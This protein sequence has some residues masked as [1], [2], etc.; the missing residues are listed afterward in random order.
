MYFDSDYLNPG[1]ILAYFRDGGLNL[2]MAILFDYT[3]F[4]KDVLVDGNQTNLGSINATAFI[5]DGSQ[6]TGLPSQYNNPFNQNLNTTD[7]V[8]FGNI[9]V[10][11][12]LVIGNSTNNIRQIKTNTN[13]IQIIANSTNSMN[14]TRVGIQVLG[15][16]AF[17]G[18]VTGASYTGGAISG[19]TGTHTGAVA[20]NIANMMNTSTNGV[21]ITDST[22]ASAAGPTR[23]SPRLLFTGRAWNG[24]ASNTVNFKQEVATMNTTPTG[25]ALRW[26]YMANNNIVTPLMELR[27]DGNGIR[28]LNMTA[29]LTANRITANLSMLGQTMMPCFGITGNYTMMNGSSSTCAMTFNCGVLNYTNC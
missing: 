23:W 22:A 7:N 15:T 8:T 25:G 4:Y 2:A 1:D 28:E 12:T 29:N 19:T 24:T 18:A 20:V 3:H 11:N 14:I 9:L 5:G 10:N 6:L 26:D 17:S 27:A 13:G 21:T 16:G